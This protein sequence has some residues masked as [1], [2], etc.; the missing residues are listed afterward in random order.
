MAI[1]WLTVV[2]QLINFLVLVYLLKRFLYQP[3]ITA[4]DNREQLISTQMTQAQQREQVAEERENEYQTELHSLQKQQNELLSQA[5]QRAEK[6]AE[7]FLQQARKKIADNRQQWQQDL[8]QEQQDFLRSLK[9]QGSQTIIHI[10]QQL[11][12]DL[13]NRPLE[14]QI[15]D[16]F[17]QQL[18]SLDDKQKQA[19]A[20]D[21]TPVH[22][23]TTFEVDDELRSYLKK[24]LQ[25]FIDSRELLFEQSAELICGIEI[26]AEGQKIS[27]TIADYIHKLEQTMEDALG[28]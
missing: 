7:Q 10:A 13:A 19:L 9:Q 2:A 14:R 8:K 21:K 15:I 24:S 20:T 11:L 4:M 22:I 18:A 25:Q 28:S 17:I 1:D 16:V 5:R 23:V 3:V 27:W 6:E 12:K 26:R